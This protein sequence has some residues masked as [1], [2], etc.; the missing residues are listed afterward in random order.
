[1]TR[2]RVEFLRLDG[3]TPTPSAAPAFGHGLRAAVLSAQRGASGANSL[4]VRAEPY[5]CCHDSGVLESDLEI[6]LLEGDLRL[7]E[8]EFARGS[9]AYLPRGLAVAGAETHGGF[10][11][12]WMG[13]G[14]AGLSQDS[15]PAAAYAEGR[16]AGPLDVNA[17]AWQ[18]VPDFPGRT[19][20]EGG[21]RTEGA[22]AAQR[23]GTPAPTR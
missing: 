13:E 6:L 22:Q 11:A 1:M 3:V 17:M 21:G 8:C 5:W 15:R 7:G 12:L 2:P 10:A 18:P 16:R 23:S 9:Y 14:R 4:L 19:S 20:E